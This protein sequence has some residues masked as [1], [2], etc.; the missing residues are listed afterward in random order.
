MNNVKLKE[1][2][3]IFRDMSK[4]IFSMRQFDFSIQPLISICKFCYEI[5]IGFN[6][7]F[8]WSQETGKC[9]I[10]YMIPITKI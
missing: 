8:F 5:L 2:L 1:I 10:F 3:I 4:V 6:I 7:Y 9:K